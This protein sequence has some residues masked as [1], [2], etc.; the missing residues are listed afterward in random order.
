M[1][2][3]STHEHRTWCDPA[4]EQPNP[5]RHLC[6][7]S[8]IRLDF[9]FTGPAIDFVADLT[10]RL[11]DDPY[12]G[13]TAPLALNDA[14]TGFTLVPGQLRP[15]AMALLALDATL[16]GDADLACYYRAEALAGQEAGA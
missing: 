5:N 11:S 9:G 3:V 16:N 13:V 2:V 7:T 1:G 15:L 12:D 4:A 8:P 14:T 10:L 6:T